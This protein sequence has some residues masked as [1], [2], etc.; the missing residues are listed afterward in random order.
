MVDDRTKLLAAA[1]GAGLLLLLASRG[2]SADGNGNGGVTDDGE[3]W[4]YD[5]ADGRPV[6]ATFVADATM[7][8]ATDRHV[9][10]IIAYHMAEMARI[11][12]VPCRM[13]YE[14]PIAESPQ[15]DPDHA[16]ERLTWWKDNV[17]DLIGSQ[18]S[19]DSNVLLF[20]G[21]RGRGWIG[22]NTA[23]SGVP[24]V[25]GMENPYTFEERRL[26]WGGRPGSAMFGVSHELL[27]NLGMEHASNGCA[28][29]PMEGR[30]DR[31]TTPMCMNGPQSD[32]NL[33]GVENEHTE[34]WG[35]WLRYSECTMS[36]W[37]V[38][39]T[40]APTTVDV[41]TGRTQ[42]TPLSGRF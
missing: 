36:Q 14:T 40:G 18:V 8:D 29:E 27:H 26:L 25:T 3:A 17:R 28:S 37:S 4:V 2:G 11:S 38:K 1:G 39:P 34:L 19:K 21:S 35:V 6:H 16:T 24:E 12:G 32:T 10:R 5:D 9:P 33:C 30:G 31:W 22:G 13:I 15:T 7:A 41:G 23:I 42:V 20:H